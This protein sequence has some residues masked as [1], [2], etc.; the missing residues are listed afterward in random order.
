M[1]FLPTNKL[2]ETV[3]N[4]RAGR[5]FVFLGGLKAA[6]GDFFGLSQIFRG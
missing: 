3:V 4:E 1:P 2:V 6:S 5:C